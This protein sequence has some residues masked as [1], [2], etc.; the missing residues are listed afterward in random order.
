MIREAM[1]FLAELKQQALNPNQIA[2]GER[3]YSDKSISPIQAPLAETL[4]VSTLD[5]FAKATLT[6]NAEV[7]VIHV[8]GFSEVNLIAR[9]CDEW[10][11]R[12]IAVKAGLPDVQGFE[13]GRFLDPETFLIGVQAKF[14]EYAD[15]DPEDDKH[16]VL[17]IASSITAEDVSTSDDDGISQKIAMRRGV[18]LKSGETLRPRVKLTP[19]RTFREIEQPASEFVLRAKTIIAGQ[20]PHLALFEADGGAWKLNAVARIESFV[21]NACSGFAVI[22]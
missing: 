21:S 13:F 5:G 18:S 9:K 14:V 16:Y 19:F 4:R 20:P 17:R 6:G 3:L 15:D 8:V 12:A 2:I 7:S 11:R 1:E 10:G 22:A